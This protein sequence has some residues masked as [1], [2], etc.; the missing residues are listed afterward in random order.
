VRFV[1]DALKTNASLLSLDLHGACV[2]RLL[3]C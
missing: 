1:A 2:S 3:R